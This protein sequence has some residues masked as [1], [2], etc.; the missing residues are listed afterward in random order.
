MISAG[1][2]NPLTAKPVGQNQ[3][4]PTS[5]SVSS[6]LAPFTPTLTGGT[7]GGATTVN[8][9]GRQKEIQ[10]EESTKIGVKK[11]MEPLGGELIDRAGAARRATRYADELKEMVGGKSGMEIYF[12]EKTGG[13]SD[14]EFDSLY[15]GYIRERVKA[16]SGVAAREEEVSAQKKATANF[17]SSPENVIKNLNRQKLDY[18]DVLDLIQSGTRLNVKGLLREP[19]KES[20]APFEKESEAEKINQILNLIQQRSNAGNK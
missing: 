16:L 4:Q 14:P 2:F 7:F 19:Q 8:I 18:D 15:T 12:N 9:P 3:A 6:P 5:R 10:A 11:S 13:F 1:Q 20:V 17:F